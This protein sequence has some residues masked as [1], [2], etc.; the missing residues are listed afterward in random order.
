MSSITDKK[1]EVIDPLYNQKHLFNI[2]I[3]NVNNEKIKF[4]IGEFLM[5][6]TV[7]LNLE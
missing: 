1:I 7:F 5:E 4:A 6:F 2:W 3:L